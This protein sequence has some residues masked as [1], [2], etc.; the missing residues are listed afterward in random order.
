MLSD[1]YIAIKKQVIGEFTKPKGIKFDPTPFISAVCKYISEDA[2]CGIMLS[3]G[4]SRA[5]GDNPLRMRE[6]LNTSYMVNIHVLAYDAEIKFNF[7][8][9]LLEGGCKNA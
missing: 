3:S 9:K 6:L 8:I 5:F 2:S 1:Q 7:L 4:S